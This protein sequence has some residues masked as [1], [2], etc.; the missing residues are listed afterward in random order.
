MKELRTKAKATGAVMLGGQLT[1][2]Y[3]LSQTLITGWVSHEQWGETVLAVPS[4]AP[5]SPRCRTLLLITVIARLFD[6]TGGCLDPLHQLI[7]LRAVGLCARDSLH[8]G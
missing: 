6:E 7:C 5:L 1:S 3:L 2:Q 4:D 8:K